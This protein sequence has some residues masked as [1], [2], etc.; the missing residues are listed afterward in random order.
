MSP[1][2]ISA[3]LLAGL[4]PGASGQG[5]PGGALAPIERPGQP[6]LEQPSLD[7]AQRK[8][9]FVLPDAS[10]L[11][12]GGERLS[13]GLLLTVRRF[14]IVGSTV[15]TQDVLNAQAAP[16]LNHPIGSE[17]LE[18]LRLRL[19][20][21]YVEAGYINSGAAIPDQDI[22]DGVVTVRIVEG[23]L[24]EVVVGGEHAF[25]A[26]FVASRLKLGAGRPLNVS[27]LQ[28]RLQLLLQ[29]PQFERINAELAPGNRLGEGVL[30]AVVTEA[31]RYT[32]GATLA[33][34]RSP[35][36]GSNRLELFGAARNLFGRAD[37]W[38]LRLGHSRGIDDY[39][40]NATI[41]LSVDDTL[42]S[43]RFDRNTSGVIE[44][45]FNT[46]DIE[47]RSRTLEI[48]LRHPWFRTL[49][50]SL[51]LGATLSSRDSVT[52]LGGEPFSFSPGVH[53][54]KSVVTALRFSAD[55]LDRGQD[56]VFSVRGVLSCG[57]DAFGATVNSDGTPDSR[58]ASGLLQAQWVHRLSEE[59]AQA[60]LRGDI[61]SSDSP[62]LSLEKFAIGGADSVRGFRENQLTR[63]RGWIGSAEIRLPVGRLPL[64][65]LFEQ[66][67]DGKIFFALFADAGR[68]WDR[69]GPKDSL[70][71]VGPGL[72]WEVSPDA[73]AQ[74][75]WA[76][77]RKKI[78]NAHNDLQDRG[79]HFRFVVHK[80]F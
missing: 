1:R 30:R 14:E 8:P 57:L 64:P 53:N 69:G 26:D 44:E 27:S 48:G 60:I 23:I 32:V 35:S 15:F 34:N 49:Q 2:I 21:L 76:G 5:L 19:T 80:Q 74:L 54:G 63:D 6:R 46:L 11:L 17:A 31:P 61:Q 37:S 55:W 25:D 71:G 28:E 59:G 51:T 33:N 56:H 12:P 77:R 29:D 42:L 3:L 79:V 75:Y 78:E 50:Q 16:F 4:A 70:W 66:P 72:R 73:H 22:K 24:A 43:L 52:Y 13:S 38:S 40:L 58:F 45:P 9:G 36:V 10:A 7:T 68:A 67:G 41:P 18:E 20:R 62:L 65:G 47:S 39:A